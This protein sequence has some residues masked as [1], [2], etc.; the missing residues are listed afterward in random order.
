MSNKNLIRIIP[1]LDIKNGMLI[2]GINLEGLRVL[3]DPLNFAKYYYNNNADEICYIDNVATLYGSNNLSNF[4]SRTAKNIFIPLS[5]GGG[6]RTIEDI[7][8]VFKSGG[9]K[10]CINSAAV[11]N[12][13]FLFKASRIFG[14]ANITIVIEYVKIKNKYFITTSHGRDLVKMD[15]IT[16]AKKAEQSGAGEIFLTS[17]NHEGLKNG[18][19]IKII[20]KISSSVSIPV[21][22]HGGA[23]NLEHILDVVKNTEISGVAISSMLHYDI[24]GTF[25]N[26]NFKTGNLNYLQN[27]KKKQ[28]SK[29]ILKLIKIYLKKKGFNVR[30]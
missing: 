6:I 1:K 16:W 27:I 15:P 3:G 29:N 24:A 26:K 7:E 18:F 14:S 4:I 28:K 23:G 5:V 12:P 30:H 25:N 19:D 10:V 9:D 11:N 8:R 22:A 17:I 21:I 13:N 2:K 20:K